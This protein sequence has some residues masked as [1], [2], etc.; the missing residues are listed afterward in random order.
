MELRSLAHQNGFDY[1]RT[2]AN[3]IQKSSSSALRPSSRTHTSPPAGQNPNHSP[4]I[5]H[6]KS[7]NQKQNR[8]SNHP[9]NIALQKQCQCSLKR[10]QTEL[11][12]QPQHPLKKHQIKHRRKNQINGSFPTTRDAQEGR[13]RLKF[14][15][16]TT[17]NDDHDSKSKSNSVLVWHVSAGHREEH[18]A[19]SRLQNWRGERGRTTSSLSSRILQSYYGMSSAGMLCKVDAEVRRLFLCV[20]F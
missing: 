12:T 3:I 1:E 15:N 7:T 9:P 8:K 5:P 11:S 16:P 19:L 20:S 17:S 2:N 13:M 14:K 18:R 10:S 6:P 4:N